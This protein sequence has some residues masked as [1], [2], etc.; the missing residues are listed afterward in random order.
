M[1]SLYKKPVKRRDP[2]T[3][4]MITMNSKKWWGRYRDEH[5][6][7]KRVPLATDKSAAQTM[8]NEAVRKAERKAAGLDD[9]FDEHRKRPLSE[10]VADFEAY[11]TNKGSTADYVNTTNQRVEAITTGCGFERID[12]I[13]ASQVHACLSD[14]RAKGKSIASSNHYL[15]A[16]KMLTRWLVRDRRT[17]DD[18]L[19]HLSKM[20]ADLDRRRIRRP[21]SIEEFG[22]LL[23][24]AEHGR[25]LQK[26]PGPDRAILYIIGAYTGY[27]R[28]EI[29]S[30][31]QQSF[32]F[33]SDPPT[34]TVAAG[35]SKRRRTD[36]LPIRRDFAERVQAWMA[37]KPGLK[38]Y[39]PLF[40]ITDKRTAEMIR[41][42]LDAARAKWL[43]EAKEEVERKRREETSFLAYENDDGH[44]V[45]FHALR[46]TFITNLTRSGVTP[47]T[48]QLLARHSDINLTMNTYTM[49]GVCDQAAAVEAL[50]PIPTSS[51]VEAQVARA[52]GTDGPTGG[53]E[54]AKMVPTVV[55][56]S[57]ENGAKRLASA[58]LRIAPTCTE[59]SVEPRSPRRVENAKSSEEIGATRA[60]LQRAASD[61]TR[62]P[63]E[64]LEPSRPCGHWILSPARLPFRHFGP[65]LK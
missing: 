15:L 54:G 6:L 1:A 37:T 29:G 9:P 26:V 58:T 43:G 5:G 63:K 46:K 23:D 31:T 10:H 16:I 7:E 12:D 34:L 64:G 28:N 61:C 59:E 49:L 11:L 45:D 25:E 44:V 50:P 51:P 33:K 47:K 30:V 62:I 39:E 22:L 32:N 53:N 40:K 13:S 27:R 19:A 17:N 14:L 2:K 41:E 57:A 35:H 38:H 4:K 52:T 8:L 36:V 21:L 18:R 48:A 60:S 3:G 20:N 24:S 42:D 55:P 56:S 65:G